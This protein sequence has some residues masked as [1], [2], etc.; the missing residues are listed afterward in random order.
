MGGA[1]HQRALEKG[2]S[3]VYGVRASSYADRYP[4]D[5]YFVIAFPCGPENVDKL[6]KA[7]LSELQ[8]LIDNGPEEK[9]LK[10]IK[11]A[12]SLELKENL[13]K[14]KYWLDKLWESTYYG[15]DLEGFESAQEKIDALTGSDIQN[16]LKKCI[17]EDEIIFILMPESEKK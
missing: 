3:G 4:D 10:K 9:D 16:A 14:N 5:Y 1:G 15:S 8:K 6:K 2:E 12:Q 13:K 11:E 7:A 17:G